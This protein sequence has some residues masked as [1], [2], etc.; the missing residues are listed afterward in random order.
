MWVCLHLDVDLHPSGSEFD[1]FD[2]CITSISQD[3]IE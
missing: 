1:P 2:D 3:V